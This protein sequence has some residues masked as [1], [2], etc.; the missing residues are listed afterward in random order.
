MKFNLVNYIYQINSFHKIEKYNCN[1]QSSTDFRRRFL[2]HTFIYL[3]KIPV[4]KRALII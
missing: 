1:E 2:A 3:L 4:T